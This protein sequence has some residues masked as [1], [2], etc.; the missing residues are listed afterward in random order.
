MCPSDG[1]NYQACEQGEGAAVT[2]KSYCMIRVIKV[3]A[4][5]HFLSIGYSYVYEIARFAL[6]GKDSGVKI[7]TTSQVLLVHSTANTRRT[8]GMLAGGMRT[9]FPNGAQQTTHQ[10][11]L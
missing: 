6:L 11:P 1:G 3:D 5:W 2:E 7:L 10:T 9:H 8:N 4:E